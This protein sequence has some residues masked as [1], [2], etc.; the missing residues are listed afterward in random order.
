MV[1]AIG[2]QKQVFE[3]KKT[4]FQLLASLFPALGK[5]DFL[6]PYFLGL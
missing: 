4:C 5:R 6:F 3:R 1:S 2:V